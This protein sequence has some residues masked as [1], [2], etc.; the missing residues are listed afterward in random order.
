MT[1]FDHEML[2]MAMGEAEADAMELIAED[3]R[4]ELARDVA[5]SRREHNASL[6]REAE[7]YFKRRFRAWGKL[8]WN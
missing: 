7:G 2:A 3:E 5:M 6:D 4:M 1:T 8:F